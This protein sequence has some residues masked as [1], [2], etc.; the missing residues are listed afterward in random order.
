M[1]IYSNKIQ[2]E[3]DTVIQ[4]ENCGNIIAPKNDIETPDINDTE[5]INQNNIIND[6]IINHTMNMTPD[7]MIK[8]FNTEI[9]ET[10]SILTKSIQEVHRQNSWRKS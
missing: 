10:N 6:D 3:H 9:F 7:S 5:V 8:L 1:Y 4:D 2:T